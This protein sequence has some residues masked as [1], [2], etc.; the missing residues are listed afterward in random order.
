MNK[1]TIMMENLNIGN[2]NFITYTDTLDSAG[3]PQVLTID[4]LGGVDL[5]EIERM[6]CTLRIG[7]Q[8]YPPYRTTLDLYNENQV[9]KLIR[10]LCDKWELKMLDASQSIN[11]LINQLEV[12]RI[13]NQN[14][15]NKNDQEFIITDE[16]R[17]KALK[18]LKSKDLLKQVTTHLNNI[19]IIGED[20]NAQIMYMAMASHRYN[21]SFSVISLAKS[22]IGKSYILQKLSE[23]MPNGSYSFHTQISDNALYY[24]D[25][26]NINNKV[27]F[28][29]D[30]EWT[31]K[32]LSPLATLQTQGKL[33]KTR[34]TKDKE[35]VINSTSFEVKGKL[36]ML[37][38][39]Y[40]DKNYENQSLPFLMLWLNHG[41]DQDVAVMEYQKKIRAGLI[42]ESLIEDSQHLLKTLIA[43]LENKRVI[44]PYAE[45]ID[46]PKDVA[47]PRK[48]L[49]L[50]LDFIE[51]IT[52]VHQKQRE[53]VVDDETGEIIGIQTAPEDIELAFKLLKD[54]LF[55][56]ADELST[57]ARNFH[58]WLTNYLDKAKTKH[59]TAF[60]IRK[61]RQMNP[62]TLNRYL[63]ELKMYSYVQITGGI[64][65]KE[66]Y[67]YKLTEFGSQTDKQS[68]IEQELNATLDKVY[69]KH[70]EMTRD[71][72]SRTVGQNA[73]SNIQKQAMK[74][75]DSRT[76]KKEKNEDEKIAAK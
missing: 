26:H 41:K 73:V 54:S 28:V 4:V 76:T 35:G 74:E 40:P 22:G 33:I 5:K 7:Y 10:K 3:S 49:L 61:E 71:K 48:S 69:T 38:T 70:K 51:I 6:I 68:R 9:D 58:T 14:Y 60:D 46:L 24:F 13:D 50:L 32:M 8:S 63:Q 64:K 36:C 47:Y 39:A 59:F 44:N 25:S 42:K 16:E 20:E 55:R 29:E 12:Y 30:L 56:R 31:K 27:L 15:K 17:K 11:Q 45:L 23:C 75:K 19:G 65:H 53:D 66:G 52:F 67:I 18:L 1:K 2:R 34:A 57:A 37:A 72:T 62:R 43:T 21:N